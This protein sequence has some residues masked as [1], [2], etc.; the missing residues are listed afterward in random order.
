MEKRVSA[1]KRCAFHAR[2]CDQQSIKGIA[3]MQG[4]FLKRQNVFKPDGKH[5]DMVNLALI[6][7]KFRQRP[8]QLKLTQL[9]LDLYFP[10]A[11]N[12]EQ[13]QVIRIPT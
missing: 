4:Q 7:D 5:P 6:A 9:G 2:L 1:Q 13:E 11:G 12:T 3:M 10:G 8:F